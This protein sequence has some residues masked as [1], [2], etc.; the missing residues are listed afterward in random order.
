MEWSS[1]FEPKTCHFNRVVTLNGVTVSGEGL[2][3]GMYV[4]LS[5]RRIHHETAKL[6][7]KIDEEV[8]HRF[9]PQLTL[10]ITAL[11]ITLSHIH[12]SANIC[13]GDER[14]SRVLETCLPYAGM[15][16]KKAQ[17]KGN[18]YLLTLC[19][20]CQWGDTPRSYDPATS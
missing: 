3:Q 19:S 18:H 20:V 17:K 5:W 6:R 2:Y 12:R 13:M 16:R 14:R 9:S 11:S 7:T 4:I 8:G 1:Y 15:D 10:R